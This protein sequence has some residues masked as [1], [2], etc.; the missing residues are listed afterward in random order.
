MFVTIR[1]ILLISCVPS[2]AMANGV[3]EFCLEGELDLGVR[4]QGTNPAPGEFYP[5]TWCVI[6]EDSSFRTLYS[7]TGLSN[8]DMDNSWAVA[9]LPPDIVRIVNRDSPP[10]VEFQGTD[11]LDEAMRVRRIDPRRLVE[12]YQSSPQAYDGVR[13]EIH[14]GRLVSVKTSAELPLR[15]RVPVD[16]NWDFTN[17]ALPVFRLMLDEEVLFRGTGRWR[18]VPAEEAEGLWEITPGEDAIQVAGDRWPARVSMR[19]INLTDDVY[20]VRGVRTGFQHL[21]IETGEG[22]VI[23]DAPAGW[24]E[25]HHIPPSDLVPGLGVSGLSEK[26]IDFIN[27]QFPERP[28]RAVALTHFHDDHAGGARAFAAA[29]AEIYASKESARFLAIALNQASM[30]K[31]RLGEDRVRVTPVINSVVIGDKQNRVKLVSMGASPHVNAM[32]GIW[33]MDKDYFFVSDVH[34]PRSDSDAPSEERAATECWFAEWAVKN[35]PSEVRIV[36]SHS[37]NETAVSRLAKYLESDLCMR[38]VKKGAS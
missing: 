27:E 30:P 18:D 10:D 22:L 21:V 15:G 3:T 29:G 23:A 24:V 37:A 7:A 26:F 38:G 17:G 4:Y 28:L 11:N 34:V 16:W 6:S 25:F 33:A 1:L 20:L 36:N 12:E 2:L 9:Y 8:P 19:V 35:L 31:D 14:N 13:V 5:T 32:L